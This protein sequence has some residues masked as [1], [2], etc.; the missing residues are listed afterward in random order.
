MSIT[1]SSV[2]GGERCKDGDA[3]AGDVAH[4]EI[5]SVAAQAIYRTY[6]TVLFIGD[7]LITRS[8]AVWL[9]RYTALSADERR[10]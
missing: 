9:T 8:E 5:W 2:R 1:A 10:A 3:T 7:S 4:P 6:S